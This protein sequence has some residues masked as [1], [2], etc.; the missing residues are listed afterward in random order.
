MTGGE[1]AASIAV[2]TGAGS[3]I[4]RA[5]AQAFARDGATTWLWDINGEGAEAA[6]T[7]LRSEGHSASA[8]RLDVGEDAAVADAI[9]KIGVTTAEIH[10][11]NCAANFVAVGPDG[12]RADW[13]RSLR[14][15]VISSALLTGK[16]SRLMLPG[17][18]VVNVSSISAHTA[19]PGRWTYNASK[20]AILALT[21]GQALD[22]RTKGIRVNAVSPGWIWTREVAKA[23]DDDRE[24]W[25]PV[26]GKYHI[27]ERLGEPA[28]VADA[29]AYLSSE[30]ASF[31]T[32]TELL[33]DG[34]YSAIGPEGL[35]ETSKFAG[36][37]APPAVN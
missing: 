31:I 25:E 1:F 35:G 30:R 36:A 10:L 28:E 21:R 34:G 37:V 3:G 20:A 2:I 5:T 27:L 32:G 33:V 18:T 24:R 11:V 9:A 23:A 7:E 19:Q 16:L 6:A 8:A 14:V 29:I 12:S 26:W 13:E 17:S 22:L 15:N 4:G